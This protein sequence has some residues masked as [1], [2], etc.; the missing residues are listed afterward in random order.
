LASHILVSHIPKSSAGIS[1]LRVRPAGG[2]VGAML[3]TTLIYVGAVFALAG[4]VKGT[5]G[6]GLPTVSMGLLAVVMP[7]VEAAAILVLPSFVTN[8][9][10]MAAGPSLGAL[11]KRLWPM[12]LAICAGTWAGLGLM[13]GASAR[14]GVFL[15]GAALALYAVAALAAAPFRLPKG[16]ERFAGPAAGL[17]TG[18]ISAATGVFVIPAVPCLQAFGLGKEELVQAL[19]LSFTVS[20]AALAVNVAAEGALGAVAGGSAVVALSLACAGMWLGQMARVRMAPAVFRRWFF[21]GLL[22]LGV[23]LMGR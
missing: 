15:L 7:P 6:L 19:G 13:T 23:Y 8:V 17:A 12:M 2:S 11:V 5:I 22:V 1:A 9:W 21:F 10:Q 20:T 3:D 18:V 4:F 16:W 14:Y